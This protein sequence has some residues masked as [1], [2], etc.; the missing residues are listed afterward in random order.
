MTGY[1]GTQSIATRIGIPTPK[2]GFIKGFHFYSSVPTSKKKGE[3]NIKKG[4]K[5]IAKRDY[6]HSNLDFANSI[7]ERKWR[8]LWKFRHPFRHTV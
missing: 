2:I 8:R 3:R 7:G 1:F 5:K 6:L 4:R